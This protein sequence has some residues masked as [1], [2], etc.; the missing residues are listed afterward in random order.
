MNRKAIQGKRTPAEKQAQR[1]AEAKE[2]MERAL[3]KKLEEEARN[4]APPIPKL[5]PEKL[6]WS[7]G[8]E[9][10]D[11][12][13]HVKE[14][15]WAA[16]KS[17]LKLTADGV[18]ISP[19]E[20]KKLFEEHALKNPN[21]SKVTN[22][23]THKVD[24]QRTKLPL[25]GITHDKLTRAVKGLLPR[26]VRQPLYSNYRYP[27]PSLPN[28]ALLSLGPDI[29]EH[30]WHE[31]IMH[32]ADASELVKMTKLKKI[33]DKM[34]AHLGYKLHEFDELYF[35]GLDKN[36][37]VEFKTVCDQLAI[38]AEK[39]NK[40]VQNIISASMNEKHPLMRLPLPSCCAI[41]SCQVIQGTHDEKSVSSSKA[42]TPIKGGGAA[43][44]EKAAADEK[45]KADGEAGEEGEEDDDDDDDDVNVDLHSLKVAYVA[46]KL[47]QHGNLRLKHV[48]EV[49]QIAMV[50][51]DKS[52]YPSNLWDMR[53]EF[54]LATVDECLT[55]ANQIRTDLD[56]HVSEETDPK[57]QLPAWMENEFKRSEVM[58]FKHHFKSIDTDGGGEID[59]EELQNLTASLG[60]KVTIEEAVDLIKV[61]D[62][63]GGGTV[64]F[65]EFMM[66]MYKIQNGVIDL[67]KN[68]LAKSMM[69]AKEQIGIFEEIEEIMR[70]PV[71]GSKV[72]H[73]G[74]QP[75]HCDVQLSG[76]VGSPY[77]GG[78]FVMRVIF[79]DG[80]P[81]QKPDIVFITRIFHVNIMLQF[82]G[83]GYLPHIDAIWDGSWNLRK[84]I[85]HALEL[86]TTAN[87][88]IIP[89]DM[90][91]IVKVFLAEKLAAAQE[92]ERNRRQ[93]IA[94]AKAERLE[95][96]AW[97]KQMADEEAE[98][99]RLEEIE[100][101]RETRVMSGEDPLYNE[102]ENEGL[103]EHDENFACILSLDEEE[104]LTA[105]MN[106]WRE[107]Y[108]VEK[109][110][111]EEAE[112]IAAEEKAIEDE[113]ER[114]RLEQEERDEIDAGQDPTL[115][116]LEGL[117]GEKE[118]VEDTSDPRFRKKVV[119]KTSDELME[120]LGR[121][122]QMHLATIQM[123]LFENERYTKAIKYYVER[124]AR[125]FEVDT[126]FKED[127]D[128][129]GEGDVSTASGSA[130]AAAAGLSRAGSTALH[131]ADP[132]VCDHEEHEYGEEGERKQELGTGPSLFYKDGRRKKNP[133]IDDESSEDDD[134]GTMQ[135]NFD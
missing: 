32:G 7:D 90:V 47:K 18:Y 46:F 1:D 56:E 12:Y 6:D 77:E 128:V 42:N 40:R 132:S 43:T 117:I 68:L 26:E 80:Y 114:E 116:L 67:G 127:E 53:G 2:A 34:S 107:H 112:R 126:E 58:L 106:T 11:D 9:P 124:F 8:E 82:D 52:R 94:E 99:R 108:A 76:P 28:H 133:E 62:L 37:F 23:Y 19:E 49:M 59:E 87:V 130:A 115:A 123:F 66:L 92:F 91:H 3:I 17:K 57:F 64:S 86:L 44:E 113:L 14:G 102:L 16:V 75:V 122:Q 96:E 109:A 31:F 22:P 95:H 78:N 30:L 83:Q 29:V 35:P 125:V 60:S 55:V 131:T 70:D 98:E 65:D 104:E 121:Q 93:E 50:P 36:D 129:E 118:E 15:K 63:D 97:E 24:H 111:T 27:L 100:N 71:P 73:Y 105:H 101:K 20:E 79:N 84:T 54:L 89:V 51:Y 72:L 103:A 21:Q 120:P 39:R 88:E 110:E 25:R 48:P 13:W 74:G 10:D 135:L 134:D 4:K 61:M 38:T 41:D 85:E 69:A 33:A 45:S 5:D 81:Y 119:S